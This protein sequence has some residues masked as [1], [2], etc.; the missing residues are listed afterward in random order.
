MSYPPVMLGSEGAREHSS[1]RIVRFGGFELDAKAGELRRRGRAVRLQDKPLQLL[2]FLLGKPTSELVTREEIQEHIWGASRFL[3]FED[4]LNQAVRKLREALRDSATKPRFLETI[5]RRGYRFLVPVDQELAGTSSPPAGTAVELLSSTRPKPITVGRRC[6]L[7]KLNTVLQAAKENGGR[8][9]C[10]SGE[11]G[12]GKTTLVEAFLG[13]LIPE[14]DGHI[15]RGRCSERLS[16]AEAYLPILEGL[17]SLTR[18]P[19]AESVKKILVDVAPSWYVQMADSRSASSAPAVLA[20]DAASASQERKKREFVSLLESLTVEQPLVFFIDDVHWA[21]VSSIDLLSYAILRSHSLP[22]LLLTTYRPSD[23]LLANHPFAE[24]KLEWQSRRLCTELEL[25]S[26]QPEDIENYIELE[27]AGNE[28]PPEFVSAVAR[29][30]EGSPLFLVDLLRD[31]RTAGLIWQEAGCWRLARPLAEIESTLP[32]SVRGMI[33]RK[34]GRLGE[35]HRKRL[36]AASV[37]GLE[38]DSA[39]LAAVLDIDVGD[40]E[41]S[42]QFLEERH[43]IIRFIDEREFPDSTLIVRYAFSHSLYQESLYAGIRPTSRVALS[44]NTAATL[45]GHWGQSSAEI[46]TQLAQL[47][48][49]AR[50]WE[51][52]SKWFCIAAVRAAGLSAYRE[53]SELSMRAVAAS[54]K[55]NGTARDERLLEAVMQ[56]ASARQ[57]L[58]QFEQSILDFTLAAETAARLEKAEAQ[59]DALCGAAFGAGMLKGTEEMRSQALKAMAIAQ[60][61]GAS[62]AKA[63]GILGYE[64]VLAGDLAAARAHLER[65]RPA[66]I[67]ER[68][69]SQA[70]FV[71]GTVGFLYDLQSEFGRA[72]MLFAEALGDR[73]R[74]ATSCA[75]VLRMTWMR[76][77][78]L[79]NQGRISDALQALQEGTKMGEIN[80]ERFWSSR[81]PNTVGWI[82][83]EVLDPETALKYN[84]LGVTAAQQAGQPEVEANSHLNLSNAYS[85]LGDLTLA[86]R[87]LSEGERI[88]RASSG[89]WLKWRFVIRLELENAS[90]WFTRGDLVKARAAATLALAKAEAVLAR[91]H[92]AWAHKLMADV[93]LLEGNAAKAAAECRIAREILAHYPCPLIEWKIQLTTRQAALLSGDSDGAEHALNQASECLAALADSIRDPE[94]REKFTSRTPPTI[95]G[96]V[97]RRAILES[98]TNQTVLS[99]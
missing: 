19:R 91:K 94:L 85:V 87:H 13:E 72:D 36:E 6:E 52:A 7:S 68:A 90:Y 37:Q 27:F 66:L 65:A 30:T 41:E 86:A 70:A 26:L 47:F 32:D 17:E 10:I 38:F 3:D 25:G 45:Q 21:D 33:A 56:L 48:E 2:M 51:A 39:I 53:A 28:F 61:T 50:D 64:R 93:D 83:S 34:I 18:G 62:S 58:S 55:L 22:V 8:V 20:A 59:I 9:F 60:A 84:L 97:G 5:P 73:M 23:M 43:R 69:L 80:G 46:G 42:L 67:Q 63:E 92:V 15:A 95:S 4:S 74:L 16:G 14:L 82:Y 1:A 88:L 35:S 76:G 96:P 89:K 71:T 99:N 29:R 98:T 44:R 40:I 31:L 12:I 11:A 79:A 75:D 57:A 54:K 24:A 49:A 77:L 81:I 78:A